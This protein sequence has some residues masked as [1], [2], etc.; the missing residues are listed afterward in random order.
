MRARRTHW[1]QSGIRTTPATLTGHFANRQIAFRH[2]LSLLIIALRICSGAGKHGEAAAK[3]VREVR[4]GLERQR[5]VHDAVIDDAEVEIAGAD[6]ESEQAVGEVEQAEVEEEDARGAARRERR[7]AR[8][9]RRCDMQPIVK[10]IKSENA[11]RAAFA[12]VM[13]GM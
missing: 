11:E 4:Q 8:P 2:R 1:N 12:S 5:Q 6:G 3:D 10:D 13:P 9:Q 7:D